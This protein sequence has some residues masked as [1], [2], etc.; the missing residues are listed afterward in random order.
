MSR[1]RLGI[2]LLILP[3]RA[4]IGRADAVVLRSALTVAGACVITHHL[5]HRHSV[6]PKY[7]GD[8]LSPSCVWGVLRVLAS[9]V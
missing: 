8:P 4:Q 3:H 1:P 5:P 7:P 9:S 6:D 2:H